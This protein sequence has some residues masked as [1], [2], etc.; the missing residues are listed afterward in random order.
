M[1]RFGL[2]LLGSLALGSAFQALGP[3][4]A[5]AQ[6]GTTSATAFTPNIE[7]KVDGV[8]KKNEAVAFVRQ[9]ECTADVTF[10][11]KLTNLPSTPINNLEMWVSAGVA[12]D[13]TQAASRTVN[14]TTPVSSCWLVATK[15][16]V[17]G[18]ATFTAAATDI[19]RDGSADTDLT[20]CPNK[21]GDKYNVYF[22]PLDTSTSTNPAS[23]PAPTIN[24]NRTATFS[25][26]TAAPNAPGGVS[27]KPGEYELKVK[28]SK[29]SG[30]VATSTYRAYF[31]T[32]VGSDK[33][34]AGTR[35]VA[36]ELFD[37]LRDADDKPIRVDNLT[38]FATDYESGTEAK[39]SDLDKRNVPI[40]NYVAAAVVHRD[41]AKNDSPLSTVVCIKREDVQTFIDACKADPECADGFES[42]SVA[43]PGLRNTGLIGLSLLLGLGV[44]V[45]V[46][47]RRH[48]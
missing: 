26:Y 20:E 7:V 15:A 30:A 34:C 36:G 11:F 40:G 42:C 3:A 1:N 38:L 46:R 39:L 18:D 23:P 6:T 24:I 16:M 9:A 4:N 33:T 47:R 12:T 22:V 37:S 28:W 5:W 21:G 19:F 14:A 13:C 8:L 48:V 2:L 44:A 35:L 43:A 29:A 10:S 45:G 31:D 27:G 32:S 17:A 41:F 25:L